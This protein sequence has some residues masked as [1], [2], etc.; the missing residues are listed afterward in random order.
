[1]D[2]DQLCDWANISQCCWNI[3]TELTAVDICNFDWKT[4]NSMGRL[5]L[6]WP[7]H[8]LGGS[9]EIQ[10]SASFECLSE[11]LLIQIQ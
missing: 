11:V 10:N 8:P 7:G 3:T 9:R 1:M 5:D 4:E 2:R 6:Q